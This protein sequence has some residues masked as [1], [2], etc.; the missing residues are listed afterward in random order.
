MTKRKAGRPKHEPTDALRKQVESMAGVGIG[1]DDIATVLELSKTTLYKHYKKELKKGH[2]KAN[3]KVAA[4][5]YNNAL[6]GNATAQIFWAKT[7]LRWKEPKAEEVEDKPKRQRAVF[8]VIPK[9]E[10]N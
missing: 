5:L 2:I 4:A 3:A 6:S 8:E 7:R 1:A 9:N 10:H